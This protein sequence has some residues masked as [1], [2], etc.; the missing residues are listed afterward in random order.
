VQ[1]DTGW[2]G[3][4]TLPQGQKRRFRAWIFTAVRSR[5][6]FV[7]A[8]FEE[9]TARA[10][11]ACEAAWEFFGGIFKVIIPDNTKAIIKKADPLE[12]R[13]TPGFLEYAQ[14]RHFHID[15]ARVRHARDKGRVER[16]VPGVRDDGFAGE[17]L[18]TLEDARAHARHWCLNDYGLRRHTRTQ[19]RPLEHF[20]AE[21][22]GRLLPAPTTPYD[23][24]RWAEPKVGRDQLAAVDK[25]VY[26]IP[27]AYV[28]QW[29][30]A[31]AD[32]H[33]VRFYLRGLLIKTHPRKAPG[34]QSI[35]ARDYPAERSVYAMRDVNALRR[36]AD[37]AGEIIGRYAAALLDS[38]L[39]WTR[40]RRVYALLG[41]VRRYGAA[42][43]TEVCTIALGA[44]ML[45]VKR[46]KRMLEQGVVTPPVTPP[47]RVIPLGRYLRPATQ[48][49][50]PLAAAASEGEE[51][52]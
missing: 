14:A 16:A 2:V 40:M 20:Q 1:L 17:V 13:I 22:Q 27:H 39:P 8:T 50:L 9:T 10:I 52:Q 3:R 18:L 51:S 25:A 45:D 23:I 46:L 12:P 47:A 44:D 6:R 31:R 4:L 32:T 7:Y 15:P 29:L 49:K 41:L 28:G 19:R 37:A 48:Y 34:G 21:E 11:E 42:R 36:Q 33:T 24:P 35:D 30:S 43:V 26:S 5:H 38:P